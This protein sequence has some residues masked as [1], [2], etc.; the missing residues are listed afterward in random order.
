[1]AEFRRG[2]AALIINVSHA[3]SDRG[4]FGTKNGVSVTMRSGAFLRSEADWLPYWS[5]LS[6]LEAAVADIKSVEDNSEDS[7][8]RRNVDCCGR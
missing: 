7:D 3:R 4:P 5:R 6:F 8:A 1:M 2:A